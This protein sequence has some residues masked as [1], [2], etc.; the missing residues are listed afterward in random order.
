MRLLSQ[1]EASSGHLRDLL[2]FDA[3]VDPADADTRGLILCHLSDLFVTLARISFL[4]TNTNKSSY[5]DSHTILLHQLPLKSL[6][7]VAETGLSGSYL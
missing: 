2:D 7:P 1:S 3:R 4:N 6:I 5:P